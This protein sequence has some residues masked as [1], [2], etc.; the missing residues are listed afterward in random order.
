MKTRS[1][2]LLCF[3]LLGGALATKV[4]L[5]SG[6]TAEPQVHREPVTTKEEPVIVEALP[7]RPE[8]EAPIVTVEPAVAPP[9]VAEPPRPNPIE[10]IQHNW[11]GRLRTVTINQAVEIPLMIDGETVGSAWIDEASKLPI[12][13]MDDETITVEYMNALHALPHASTNIRELAEHSID[14]A[15]QLAAQPHAPNTAQPVSSDTSNASN[16]PV[17]RLSGTFPNKFPLFSW[18]KVP[19]YKMFGDGNGLTDAQAQFIAASTDFVCFEK[20]HGSGQYQTVEDGTKHDIALLK[21]ENPKLKALMYL[22]GS[23]LWPNGSAVRALFDTE[24]ERNYYRAPIKKEYEAWAI[25]QKDGTP[26]TRGTP[27]FKQFFMNIAHPEYQQW[28]VDTA[29]N[30]VN[31]TEADGIYIDAFWIPTFLMKYNDLTEDDSNKARK[32]ILDALRAE[33]GPDKIIFINQG[34]AVGVL[35]DGGEG[36]MF[37]NYKP[38]TCTPEE[39]IN[40]WKQMKIFH[41]RGKLSVWRIGVN[42]TGD[43]KEANQEWEERS[44]ELATFWTAAFLIGAQEYS[45]FQYG[46]GFQLY[47]GGALVDYPEFNKRLGA[48]KGDYQQ[49]SDFVFTRSFEFAEV[50]VDLQNHQ[51]RIDWK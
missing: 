50:W 49:E 51:A 25:K 10:W 6:R 21:K 5:S 40:D 29:V 33:L 4:W 13:A 34:N 16:A 35:L 41:D 37:E 42:N 3:I 38:E 2:I 27:R 36:F 15:M 28:W 8:P 17:R 7:T 30:G 48:P 12:H 20:Q 1:L 11:K 24:N 47:K 39:I 32:V 14:R 45:Y 31:Y 18:D 43:T 19:V 46:W 44:E 23:I 22:N 9:V 26:Y